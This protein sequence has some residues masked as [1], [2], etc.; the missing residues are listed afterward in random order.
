MIDHLNQNNI[1]TRSFIIIK[2]VL[3]SFYWA[4]DP[5]PSQALHPFQ[6]RLGDVED[7]AS[8]LSNLR[9][10]KLR[11]ESRR[12]IGASQGLNQTEVPFY[13]KYP[14][15]MS[16]MKAVNWKKKR[17]NDSRKYSSREE[18]ALAFIVD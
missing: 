18:L 5:L 4:P 11:P 14:I 10:R 8:F 7:K 15:P 13:I 2:I 17:L 1:F 16:S 9:S 12:S 6:R 3:F